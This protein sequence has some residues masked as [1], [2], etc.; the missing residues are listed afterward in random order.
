MHWALTI[1]LINASVNTEKKNVVK[2]AFSKL[3]Y[4]K[5][6]VKGKINAAGEL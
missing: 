5:T 2:K 3:T 1:V 6:A 4:S